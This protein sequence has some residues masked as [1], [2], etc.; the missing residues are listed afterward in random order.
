MRHVWPLMLALAGC[1]GAD[2]DQVTKQLIAT[3][4]AACHV[5][6]GIRSA[7]GHVGPSLAG[8]AT[9]QYIAGRLPNTP[10]NLRAFLLH[11]Q[12]V[13]PGGAMPELGLTSQQADAIAR[14]LAGSG[15]D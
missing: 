9:R 1:S 13:Q 5:V 3:H 15:K 7:Q 2:K 11:P 6:P 8:L 4:C 10:T 14:Y 12:A